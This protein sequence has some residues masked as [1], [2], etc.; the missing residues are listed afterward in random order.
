MEANEWE[1]V[2]PVSCLK[3]DGIKCLVNETEHNKPG[4]EYIQIQPSQLYYLAGQQLHP[5]RA[6]RFKK[7]Y[8]ILVLLCVQLCGKNTSAHKRKRLLNFVVKYNWKAAKCLPLAA[9]LKFRHGWRA[10]TTPK[11]I[12]EIKINSTH[13]PLPC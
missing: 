4:T 12:T 2:L 13:S 11:T 3:T 5:H 6:Y 9:K 8:N 10:T 7:L 1:L